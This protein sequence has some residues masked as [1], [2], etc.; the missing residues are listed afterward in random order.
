MY[1]RSLTRFSLGK[2]LLRRSAVNNVT[3]IRGAGF[4]SKGGGI[5]FQYYV[6]MYG[7]SKWSRRPKCEELRSRSLVKFLGRGGYN[8]PG[9][10]CSEQ[11]PTQLVTRRGS[12]VRILMEGICEKFLVVQGDSVYR[13]RATVKELKEAKHD[14]LMKYVN[15]G[16]GLELLIGRREVRGRHHPL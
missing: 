14:D 5:I 15:P 13:A 10:A 9:G 4:C 7:E 3:K 1:F 11:R 6:M 12:S 16:L 8:E 2:V